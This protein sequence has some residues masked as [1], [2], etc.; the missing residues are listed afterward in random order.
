LRAYAS[1]QHLVRCFDV[2]PS[3]QQRTHHLQMAIVGSQDE[4]RV[5]VLPAPSSDTDPVANFTIYAEFQCFTAW[6]D[7]E[8]CAIEF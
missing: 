5:P 8:H 7:R 2:R 4:A 1:P 3:I 6:D